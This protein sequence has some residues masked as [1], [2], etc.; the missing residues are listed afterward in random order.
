MSRGEEKWKTFFCLGVFKKIDHFFCVSKVKSIGGME[1]GL[2]TN[3][4]GV[5]KPT[6]KL[7]LKFE[8]DSYTDLT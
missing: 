2:K 5:A 4:N 3:F 6:L 7:S 1:G 8:V